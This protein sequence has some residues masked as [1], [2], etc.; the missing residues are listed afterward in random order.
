MFL[1]PFLVSDSAQTWTCKTQISRLRMQSTMRKRTIRVHW[2]TALLQKLKSYWGVWKADHVFVRCSHARLPPQRISV[3]AA[4]GSYYCVCFAVTD[5][6]CC[7]G[8]KKSC[9]KLSG[10]KDYRCFVEC[11]G[12]QSIFCVNFFDFKMPFSSKCIMIMLQAFSVVIIYLHDLWPEALESCS[13][14]K[15]EAWKLLMNSHQ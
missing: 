1:K 15:F 4:N 14:D 11:E 13:P 10:L 12:F 2:M 3:Q 5:L 8:V 6:L 7:I 9:K